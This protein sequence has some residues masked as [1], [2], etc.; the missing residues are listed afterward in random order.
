V[1]DAA[2]SRLW[3]RMLGILLTF[4]AAYVALLLLLRLLEP[5][6]VFHPD[7]P[8]RL[9]GDW[10]PAGL[11]LEDVWLRASDGVKLHA[12]W[13]PAPGA[14]RTAVYFHGNAS[15]LANRADIFRFLHEAGVNVL[16]VEYR[17]YGKSEGYPGEDGLYLDA[18][19][20]YDYL[21]GTRGIPAG[22]IV[23][24]GASLGSAVA[25][26]LAANR[27]VG[28]VILEAPFPSAQAVA[29]R[30]FPFLPGAGWVIRSRFDVSAKLAA[31]R[32][33]LLV[34]HCERDPV[35]PFSLGEAVFAAAPEPK[36]FLRLRG[37]F[38]EGAAL[39]AP[40]EVREQL[41]EF[42]RGLA[43]KPAA[44]PGTPEAGKVH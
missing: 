20:A 8:S 17:G 22:Q 36:M 1:A 42:L 13:I 3:K 21:T 37:G 4:G 18:Q 30:I 2:T 7:F 26:D 25:A 43:G 35:I 24:Y 44:E 31:A 32:T 27:R 29:Q 33:P 11:P 10:K 6:V 28:G 40:G 16:G 39:E 38:H 14:E 23:S 19:A 5:Q 12:W 9:E 41:L 34:I 15:N